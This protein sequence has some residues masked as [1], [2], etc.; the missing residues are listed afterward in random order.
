MRYA[1]IA[2][3]FA[4]IAGAIFSFGIIVL[5]HTPYL[6]RSSNSYHKFIP[7][8]ETHQEAMA[9]YEANKEIGQLKKVIEEQKNIRRKAKSRPQAGA[10]YSKTIGFYVGWDDR[11][12]DSLYHHTSNL[13][14]VI[15][16]WL[17]LDIKARDR[18]TMPAI[19]HTADT[20]FIDL[21]IKR[22]LPIVPEINNVANKAFQWDKLRDLLKDRD[23]QD[24]LAEN[25]RLPEPSQGEESGSERGRDQY[26]LRAPRRLVETLPSGQRAEAKN[27]SSMSFLTS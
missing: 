26:R 6:A 5:P 23:A 4:S 10:P 21:C 11:S 9:R 22:K 18:F 20:K 7:R 16:E 1:T 17:G 15:P 14:Y 2:A 27:S 25:L 19:E 12:F 8:L 3:F 13:T 24:N